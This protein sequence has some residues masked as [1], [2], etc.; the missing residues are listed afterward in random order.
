M[1]PIKAICDMNRITQKELSMKTGFSESK[2]SRWGKLDDKSFFN[3]V[4][5]NE[6]KQLNGVEK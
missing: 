6:W 5:V 1:N 2:I 4:S 3:S